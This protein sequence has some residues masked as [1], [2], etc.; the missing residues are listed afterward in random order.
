[1][2]DTVTGSVGTGVNPSHARSVWIDISDGV[3]A[4]NP[5][6]TEAQI[7]D[8]AENRRLAD[9]APGAG[10]ALEVEQALADTDSVNDAELVDAITGVERLARWAAG[11][12]AE[13][14]AEFARRRPGTSPPPHRSRVWSPGPV[15]RPTSWVWR[16][17]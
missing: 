2:I 12:Q 6:L 5:V 3:W 4:C 13:L 17:S 7:P 14:V 10:S 9:M 11:V 16:W 1:M 8:P 15:G